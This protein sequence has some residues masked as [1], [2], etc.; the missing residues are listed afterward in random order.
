MLEDE[1]EE[2][3]QEDTEA[4]L[5]NME[6]ESIKGRRILHTLYAWATATN[7]TSSCV[8]IS[9]DSGVEQHHAN[10]QSAMFKPPPTQP[11][12]GDDEEDS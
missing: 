9:M 3:S 6:E 11:D 5:E 8:S 4:V 12:E 7:A 1:E 10:I 2:P